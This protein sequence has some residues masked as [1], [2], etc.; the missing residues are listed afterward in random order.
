MAMLWL[1]ILWL[2]WCT[3]HSLLITTGVR[4]WFERKG[5]AWFGLYRIGY[6][7][8][9]LCSLLPLLWYTTTLPQQPLD[10]PSA[11]IQSVQWLLFLYALVMFIGGLR[12][13]DLQAFLGFRQWR[14]YRSGRTYTAPSLKKTGI[15]RYV[16]H[17][18]YSGGIAFLWSLP[19]LTDVTLITRSILT[20]YLIVGTL[21]EERKLRHSL[22]EPYRS[23]CHEVPM[24]IPWK[25]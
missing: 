6:A 11:C 22:G 17:P 21:L 10:L 18:W 12:V 8:F 19:E 14:D 3:V 1:I 15:L 5:A 24:L 25:F 16:R 7:C 4:R 13:Y 20:A 2:A 9:S 23:Y